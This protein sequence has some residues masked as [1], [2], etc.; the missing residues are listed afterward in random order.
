MD[1]GRFEQKL[2]FN[3][4][5]IQS[6]LVQ[7]PTQVLYPNNQDIYLE[8]VDGST[9]ADIHLPLTESQIRVSHEGELKLYS[10]ELISGDQ[11]IV[12]LHAEEALISFVHYILSQA[13]QISISK[14]IRA[15]HV[16]SLEDLKQVIENTHSF[17]TN[18]QEL[19]SMVEKSIMNSF[20][21][22]VSPKRNS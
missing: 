3:N 2:S 21:L 1:D 12:R 5:L 7:K 4:P 13:H 14:L 6:Q 17:K 19:L 10:L 11:T 9:P 20:R 18:Y 15:V 8:F 22:H 16:P